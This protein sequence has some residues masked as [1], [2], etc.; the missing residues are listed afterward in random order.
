ME[1]LDGG[2]SYFPKSFYMEVAEKD[3]RVCG[4]E[5]ES[6]QVIELE[7]EEEEIQANNNPDPLLIPE[8]PEPSPREENEIV[9]QKVTKPLSTVMRTE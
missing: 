7:E 8:L 6:E 1:T 9:I 3:I 5:S 4:D 2:Q